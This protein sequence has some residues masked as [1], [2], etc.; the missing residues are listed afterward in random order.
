M[1]AVVDLV[2]ADRPDVVPEA[3]HPADGVAVPVAADRLDVAADLV[4]VGRPDVVPEGR[5]LADAVAG[6]V[7]A[8]RLDVQLAGH[9]LR[10][11]QHRQERS[12]GDAVHAE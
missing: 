10:L 1:D 8:D 4:A 12:E 7:A 9:R 5:H 6:L 2:A 11:V 3:Q